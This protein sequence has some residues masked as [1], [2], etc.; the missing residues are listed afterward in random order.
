MEEERV[1]FL[2]IFAN[3]PDKIRQEDII[4]V[5]DNNPYTWNAA[6]FE[7]KNNTELGKRILMKLKELKII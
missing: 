7:I 5:V 3:L 1:K 2:K 4:A 6:Y